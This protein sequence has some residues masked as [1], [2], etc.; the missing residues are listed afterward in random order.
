MSV[1]P[2]LLLDS[3]AMCCDT[4]RCE[5]TLLPAPRT[6][7]PSVSHRKDFYKVGCCRLGLP[8]CISFLASRSY[9]HALTY[10][11]APPRTPQGKEWM[12]S[13]DKAFG[14]LGKDGYCDAGKCH[15]FPIA[16]GEFG[17]RFT[18]PEDLAHLNDLALY[19]NA[20][21]AGNTGGHTPVA[22]WYYWCWNANSGDTGG[23]VDDSW[24]NL[25]WTKL[26]WLQQKLG[27]KPWYV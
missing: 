21:G 8:S 1:R 4:T 22:N 10:V 24:M 23:L 5:R 19:L 15:V 6:D 27:L 26:R 2:L 14:Y 11:R 3:N 25:Q 7:G 13:L 18:E 17:S 9:E 20:Q 12:L 16:V